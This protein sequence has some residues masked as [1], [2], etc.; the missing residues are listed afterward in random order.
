MNLVIMLVM[1]NFQ[2]L[3]NLVD[4]VSLVIL[5]NHLV[6]TGG[7]CVNLVNLENHW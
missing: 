3:V 6:V 2:I 7:G 5:M 4:L 1:F